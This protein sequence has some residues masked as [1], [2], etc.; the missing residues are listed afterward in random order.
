MFSKRF[1]K[2]TEFLFIPYINTLFSFRKSF[3]IEIKYIN[4]SLLINIII[5]NDN[6]CN[7][8]KG[9]LNSAI[10]DR[11]IKIDDINMYEINAYIIFIIF[12]KLKYLNTCLYK[13]K[14]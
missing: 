14:A 3:E 7:I 13:P 8:R 2:L 6:D 9:I 10:L 4:K 1:D 11:K 12:L 5:K